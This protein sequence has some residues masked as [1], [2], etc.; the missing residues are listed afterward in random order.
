MPP[1]SRTCGNAIN[2]LLRLGLCVPHHPPWAEKKKV[3][4][5]LVLR[6]K[7]M[8]IPVGMGINIALLM[9]GKTS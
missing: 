4:G 9:A 6:P 8:N 3:N 5:D 1:L 2:L 7:L